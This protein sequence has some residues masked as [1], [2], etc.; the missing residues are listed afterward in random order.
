MATPP[1]HLLIF[2]MKYWWIVR[3]AAAGENLYRQCTDLLAVQRTSQSLCGS[4]LPFTS[5][6]VLVC[7]SEKWTCLCLTMAVPDFF[8][9]PL[10]VPPLLLWLRRGLHSLS[11]LSDWIWT[12]PLGT[13]KEVCNERS[14]E[15]LYIIM[16]W[17]VDT[18]N[19]LSPRLQIFSNN[20][21]F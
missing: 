11:Q 1:P 9:D 17:Q 3:L 21:R 14:L 4:W 10:I 6:P 15:H 5:C 19:T 7:V 20:S 12:L 2:N 18:F 8:R 13:C 16:A